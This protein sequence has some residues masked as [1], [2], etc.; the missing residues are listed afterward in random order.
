M[1]QHNSLSLVYWYWWFHGWI[2]S[3]HLCFV[4][5]PL[6]REYVALIKEREV[7]FD[8]LEVKEIYQYQAI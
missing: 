8:E 1:A 7:T 5:V 3:Y 4:T 6:Q 2:L